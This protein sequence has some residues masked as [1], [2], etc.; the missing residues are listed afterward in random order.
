MEKRKQFTF[1]RSYYDALRGQSARRRLG[2]LDA[3]IAFGLDGA[4]PQGLDAVQMMAF[5]LIRPT[6]EASRRKALGGM[7]SKR[8]KSS[9]KDTVNKKE[10]EIEDETEN[11]TENENE[12]ETEEE[13][14]KREACERITAFDLFWDAYP[15]EV[16]RET[17]QAAW[18]RLKPDPKTVMEGL[19]RWKN[20]LQWSQEN[21]RFI[22][23]AAKFL[24][25]KHYLALP[26]QKTIWGGTGKLGQAELEA[27]ERILQEGEGGESSE[28]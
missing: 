3:I 9:A 20:S 12:I 21:G 16:G 26:K 11:E 18:Y 15:S 13:S 19:E 27:I 8:G 6:L 17:A 10:T 2:I 5:Q 28:E 24:Q 25:E 14:Q 7:K 23:R 4:E 22:P 1:Y